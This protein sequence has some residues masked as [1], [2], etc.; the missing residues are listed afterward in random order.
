MA[1]DWRA[2]RA[3]FP[4][5]D[6]CIYLN[7]GWSGP[8]SRETV[9][10]MQARA[11]REAFEGPTSP[12]VRN[13]KAGL[14]LGARR[15]V[16]SLIGADVDEVA[17]MYTTTEA[18]NT[19]LRGIGLRPGDEV[20]TCNMEHNAI[21]VPLYVTRDRDG[22]AASV[23]R[24]RFDEDAQQ[25]IDAFDRAISAKTKLV[26]ISHISWNR[27][28]RLPVRDICAIA[29]ARGAFVAVDAAQSAGQV[30]VDVR[31]QDCDVLALPGHKWLLGPDGAA[32]MYVRRRLIERLQPLAVVH[33]ANR[34]YDFEG[35]FEYANDT[36]HKFELTTHSGPVL[37]GL[38][39]ALRHVDEIGAPA[40][41][42]R[43]LELATRFLDG[44]RG[45]DRVRITTPLDPTLRSGIVTF[46]V[47][48]E[49]PSEVCA[50]LWQ[51]ERIVGRV[52]N[53][54]RVRVCWHI[55]NDESDVD[56][57]VNAVARIARNGIP[58]GTPSEGEY[59]EHLLEAFD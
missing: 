55:F 18:V 4:V 14:V 48:D 35:H 59:K 49:N 12:A 29:H 2:V 9:E 36:I 54:R 1:V 7:T 46:T 10:A 8:C 56:R 53:D 52:C 30:S 25:I 38:D 27:G 21:M 3:R 45:I 23:L 39:V 50:A 43:C 24:F 17:L 6:R 32:F 47:G 31:G 13:E 33:G 28:T 42:E 51:V 16:A 58:P 57:T 22:I 11:A 37:A 20:L 40:I 44:L 41:E 19:V 26:L 34:R 15:A 5:A